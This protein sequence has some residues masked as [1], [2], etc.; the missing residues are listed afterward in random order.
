ML[1]GDWRLPPVR[2][3]M[4]RRW[5]HDVNWF[6][7]CCSLAPIYATTTTTTTSWIKRSERIRITSTSFEIYIII[8]CRRSDSEKTPYIT[9]SAYSFVLS[10][11][12]ARI[13]A[14][15]PLNYFLWAVRLF[16]D[17]DINMRFARRP[18]VRQK[19]CA[20]E[21]GS[22]SYSDRLRHLDIPTLRYMRY[23]GDM[24]ETYKILHGIYDTTVSPCLPRCQFSGTR[25]NSFKLVKRIIVDMIFENTLSLKKLL[26]C[27][28]ACH[29]TLLT[30]SRLIVLSSGVVSGTTVRA[31]VLGRF[32]QK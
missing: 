23:R 28:I 19:N 6:R 14:E 10:Q 11:F 22:L 12:I 16:K 31:L 3:A 9:Y 5:R 18:A 26:T 27:E 13:S 25:G 4:T 8:I 2:R 21:M 15:S 32:G 29:H 20:D 17:W 7:C 1:A 24:I 30:L